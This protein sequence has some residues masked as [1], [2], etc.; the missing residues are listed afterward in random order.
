M[1]VAALMLAQTATPAS[2]GQS[3]FAY[4]DCVEQTVLL[5]APFDVLQPEIP[6]G[7][8]PQTVGEFLGFPSPVSDAPVGAYNIVTLS[9]TVSGKHAVVQEL[10]IPVNPPASMRSRNKAALHFV[11]LD[12]VTD[13]S[14][15][16]SAY[17]QWCAPVRRGQPTLDITTTP[18]GDIGRA[19]GTGAAEA[20]T[21]VAVPMTQ[22]AGVTRLFWPGQRKPTI[23]DVTEP[24][25]VL[26][27]GSAAAYFDDVPAPDTL[28][29][30]PGLG[31]HI[32][33]VGRSV[34]V[35]SP[36]RTSCPPRGARNKK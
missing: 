7:F 26:T 34:N 18:A 25:A 11:V 3:T 24:P 15:V 2:A 5:P 33:H 22:P 12:A 6:A 4:H 13:S 21:H 30:E 8:K 16:A 10:T 14:R 29:F 23:L 31:A 20:V 36:V 1:T 35:V 28:A 32:S 9:C 27:V 17:G 19:G